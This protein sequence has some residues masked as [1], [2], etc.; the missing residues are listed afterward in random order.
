MHESWPANSIFSERP[1][2][3][4]HDEHSNCLCSAILWEKNLKVL[5]DTRSGTGAGVSDDVIVTGER[6][7]C[8]MQLAAKATAAP[9]MSTVFRSFERQPI[10]ILLF[11]G[12]GGSAVLGNA[13]PPLCGNSC[14]E[15]QAACRQCS[16]PVSPIPQRYYHYDTKCTP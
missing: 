13:R 7:A 2:R 11:S 16:Q 5:S 1:S 3:P 15:M 6:G 10:S 14:T 9:K 8:W 12:F 4:W